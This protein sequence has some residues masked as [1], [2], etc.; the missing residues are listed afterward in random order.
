MTDC[1]VDESQEDETL[2]P[3]REVPKDAW[4]DAQVSVHPA[5]CD[6]CF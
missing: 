6:R 1:E 3:F 2:A 5:K 4:L